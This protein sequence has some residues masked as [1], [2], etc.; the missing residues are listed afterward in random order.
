MSEERMRECIAQYVAQ[1]T[2]AALHRAYYFIQRLFL[3][4]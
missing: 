1:L 4:S 3:A 2:G